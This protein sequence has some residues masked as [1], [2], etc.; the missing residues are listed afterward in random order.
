MNATGVALMLGLVAALGHAQASPHLVG[1]WRLVS[2]DRVDSTGHA[3]PYWDARPVGQLIYTADGHMAAQLYDARRP[4]LGVPI[5]SAA[6]ELVRSE[7]SSSATYFGTYTV[8][9]T[10]RTVTH[11]VEGAWLPDWLGRR[12]VRS[13]RFIAPNRLELSVR[14]YVLVWER[15]GS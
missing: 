3:E 12:L 1:T 6:A 9:T 14:P 13:F 10:S 8:D 15:I 11:I 2:Y 7:Y 5:D 4:R